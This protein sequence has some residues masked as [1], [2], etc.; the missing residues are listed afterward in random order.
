MKNTLFKILLMVVLSANAALAA[1]ETSGG[2]FFKPYVGADY[3]YAKGNYKSEDG[4]SYSDIFPDSF[5]GGDVHVGARIHQYLGIEANYFDTAHANKSNI[6]GTGIN[7][8]AKFSGFAVDA[9]GYLPLGDKRF[10]LIGTVG[11]ARTKVD[12]KLSLDGFFASE[13]AHEVKPRIGLGAQYWVTDNLNIREIIRYQDANFDGLAKN[14][15][16]GTIGAN[17][18]F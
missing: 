3:Q 11:V 9:L 6:L 8:S 13:N 16:I 5:N 17:W 12:G 7:S 18:Q 4:I 10:E 15:I 14:I 2:F 1:P